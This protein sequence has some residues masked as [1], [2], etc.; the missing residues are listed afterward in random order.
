[1][2]STFGKLSILGL[3]VSAVAFTQTFQGTLRGRVVDPNGA[4]TAS[5][6]ITLTDEG[7]EIARN[8]LTN[9]DGEYT[10]ASVT[11]ATY[12]LTVDAAG[13]KKLEQKGV[14]VAIKRRHA[15]SAIGAGPSQ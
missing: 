15:G 9:A 1:M 12:T 11:L 4:V 6:K 8:T 14:A 5:A 13:F 7:T 3:L 10:F 2:K